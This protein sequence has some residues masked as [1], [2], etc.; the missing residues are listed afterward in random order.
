MLCGKS[1]D[2]IKAGEKLYSATVCGIDENFSLIVKHDGKKE[3]L[4]TGEV[5]VREKSV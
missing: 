5:S 1:V 2:V 4:A 3:T